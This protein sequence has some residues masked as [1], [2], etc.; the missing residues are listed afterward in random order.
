MHDAA[1]ILASLFAIFVA[2]QVGAEIAQ[3]LR[4]PG[5][6]GEIV[7]G[8]VIG[9]S[10]LGLIGADTIAS[11]T[12]SDVLAEIGVVLLLFA[13]GLETRLDELR[14]VGRSAA[15][16]CVLGVVVPFV[17]GSAW[18]HMSGFDLHRSLFVGPDFVLVRRA[19]DIFI[20]RRLF[21]V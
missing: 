1:A 13:V 7:A 6:V 8:C 3:R 19:L 2:A 16:V 15:L 4:L 14:K 12:P 21:R 17:L 20:N 18:A 9:P 11:G 5:V 10:A